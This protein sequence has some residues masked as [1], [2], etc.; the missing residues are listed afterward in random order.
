VVGDLERGRLAH[1]SLWRQVSA[2]AWRPVD[3]PS[4]WAVPCEVIDIRAFEGDRADDIWVTVTP[5][6]PSDRKRMAPDAYAIMRW[7]PGR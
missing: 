2:K 6:I 3:V 7:M 1:T 4:P 5:Q